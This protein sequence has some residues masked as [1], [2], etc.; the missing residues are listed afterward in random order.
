MVDCSTPIRSRGGA[1]TI[2]GV[3]VALFGLGTVGAAV[4]RLLVDDGWRR[5]VAARGIEPPELVAVGVRAPERTRAVDLPRSVRLTDDLPTLIEATDVDVV[6][7]LI[8]GLQPAGD[9]IDA[10]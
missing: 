4:A 1:G 8:G 5:H 3:R 7:E 2:G 10:A 9:L 6:V